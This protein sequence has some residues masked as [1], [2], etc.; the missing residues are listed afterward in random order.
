MNINE[1]MNQLGQIGSVGYTPTDEVVDQLVGRAKRARAIRQGSAALVGTIG[2]I[3]LGLIGA[4][5][6][7]NISHQE[8]AG[9]AD[10]N[11]NF[12]NMS[13]DDLNGKGYTGQG[14]SQD[15]L[16]KAWQ[17]LKAAAAVTVV[18]P[19]P[20][21]A[22]AP[23]TPTTKPASC[24]YEEHPWEDGVKYRSPETGCEWVYPEPEPPGVPSGSI[25]FGGIVAEC[26]W[27]HDAATNTDVWAAYID[28]GESW[29]KIVKC[30][31]GPTDYWAG[32]YRY[33]YNGPVGSGWHATLSSPTCTG[34]TKTEGRASTNTAA[35]PRS[36]S[37]STSEKCRH[38]SRSRSRSRAG[39]IDIIGLPGVAR[40]P[41]PAPPPGPSS[42]KG[43]ER[44]TET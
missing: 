12:Q 22:P 19:A 13:F 35:T 30:D 10:R 8:D 39:G 21:P 14:K 1:Q 38:R 7:V 27:Y 9:I 26:K 42:K 28:A 32:S 5:V 29:K 41:Q 34:F 18:A 40:F 4:Q 17:D 33:I 15:E 24:V 3:G 16:A 2:A 44:V 20:A 6:I 25:E 11:F 31:G 23:K 43:N 36:P 37:G